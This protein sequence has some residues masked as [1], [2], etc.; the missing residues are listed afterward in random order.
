MAFYRCGGGADTSIVT[1]LA[2]D[3]LSPKVI[4][5]ADGNPL[6]G[7]MPNNGAV[8]PTALNCGGSYTIP[9]GYH[10]GSGKVTANSLAS[11]T[12]A[13]ATAGNILSGKTAWV[14]GSKITGSMTN[15]GAVSQALDADGSYTIPAGY[16]NGS[17]KVTA[18]SLSSQGAGKIQFG[19]TM[20]STFSFSGVKN[21][22]L[23]SISGISSIPKCVFFW[24][25][26]Y[27][28]EPYGIKISDGIDTRYCAHV[29]MRPEASS[30][31]NGY[32]GLKDI[33]RGAWFTEASLTNAWNIYF[34]YAWN[35][36]SSII[37]VSLKNNWSNYTVSY[38]D[39][40][41]VASSSGSRLWDYLVVF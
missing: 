15:R 38:D 3:V 36:A 41:S 23:F 14:N 30:D 26:Y 9:K 28:T 19:S 32:M 34:S 35:S 5:D 16:H 24:D 40:G 2:S 22:T 29:C 21:K 18:N 11:Q 25:K 4:V 39:I 1:A 31:I 6:T 17:G 12:S 8:S 13:D 7:T 10:N 33:T 27:N 20:I 37:T